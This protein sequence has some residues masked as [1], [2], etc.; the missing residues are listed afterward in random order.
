VL[1]AILL[2]RQ[3]MVIREPYDNPAQL[4]KLKARNRH[5]RRVGVGVLLC[6]ALCT[7]MLTVVKTNDTRQVELS[8][9]EAYTVDAE[10][11]VVL[12]PMETVSDGHLHRLNTR[13]R[14][15]STSAG[16]W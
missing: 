4:R 15:I 16:S 10:A 6:V 3:G 11:G 1:L 14:R 5:W 8:A 7:V 2:F 12:V 13:R 9:P